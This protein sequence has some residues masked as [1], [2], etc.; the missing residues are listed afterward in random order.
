M[1]KEISPGYCPIYKKLKRSFH[2]EKP[3][4]ENAV[5]K[6]A[7]TGEVSI[8]PKTREGCYALSD[9]HA[10]EEGSR[11]GSEDD[12]SQELELQRLEEEAKA[13]MSISRAN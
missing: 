13:C 11:L 7:G 9:V 4:C 12:V 8:C 1:L 2:L 10:E 6:N 5:R 3:T